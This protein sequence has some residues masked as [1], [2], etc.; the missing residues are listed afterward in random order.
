MAKISDTDS[1]I[2]P[3]PEFTSVEIVGPTVTATG[4]ATAYTAFVNGPDGTYTYNWSNSGGTA[5]TANITFAS[6]GSANLTCAVTRNGVTKT[7][8][9]GVQV[10]D[11]PFGVTIVGPEKPDKDTTQNYVASVSGPTLAYT[12]SWSVT[13]GNAT[14]PG[15]ADEPAVSVQL[16][17][18]VVAVTLQCVVSF[19]TT[20]E[21]GTLP[22]AP[23]DTV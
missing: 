6:A 16:A 2:E 12:Y 17:D 4:A 3:S 19:G 13:S 14:I 20:N 1:P 10:F 7:G 5:A 9:L 11:A 23:Q 18:D 21:T 22:I 8:E 15:A